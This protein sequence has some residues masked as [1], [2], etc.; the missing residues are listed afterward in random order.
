MGGVFQW[1]VLSYN[2]PPLSI[3]SGVGA[4]ELRLSNLG[5]T[6]VIVNRL[7]YTYC[8][9]QPMLLMESESGGRGL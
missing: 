9:Q 7:S 4:Q 2:D 3:R 5:M 8:Q 6:G 1:P